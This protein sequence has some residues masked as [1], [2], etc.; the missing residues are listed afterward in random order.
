MTKQ[1]VPLILTVAG[2]YL[3]EASVALAQ[4]RNDA[5]QAFERCKTNAA[6]QARL[7]CFKNLLPKDFSLSSKPEENPRDAWPLIR[8]PRPNG[9]PDAIATM[10]TADTS[11]SDPDLAGLMIRCREK[12]GMEVLL[13]LVRP[14]PPR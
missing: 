1:I 10:R 12:S 8:T 2:M 14:F 11:R 13:A 4:E 6:D 9:G 5:V 3:A 7:D